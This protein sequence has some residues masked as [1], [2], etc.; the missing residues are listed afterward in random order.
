MK[1][2]WNFI[3]FHRR[4]SEKTSHFLVSKIGEKYIR[5]L[6][7]LKIYRIWFSIDKRTINMC[8]NK[9]KHERYS[10][11]QSTASSLLSRYGKTLPIPRRK[12][13]KTRI[14]V[15][16]NQYCQ[17]PAIMACWHAMMAKKIRWKTAVDTIKK[18]PQP[19][20]THLTIFAMFVSR[21]PLGFL[22]KMREKLA[23]SPTEIGVLKDPPS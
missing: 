6:W 19:S 5:H 11:H 14:F 17:R 1:F 3:A 13:E 15:R 2:S 23:F 8:L 12:C 4:K 20:G 9:S 21:K 18:R 10:P 16:R 7:Y 22:A